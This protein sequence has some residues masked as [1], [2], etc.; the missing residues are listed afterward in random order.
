MNKMKVNEHRFKVIDRITGIVI[1]GFS[2]KGFGFPD[3]ELISV[4]LDE[5]CRVRRV[6]ACNFR[7]QHISTSEVDL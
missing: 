2:A 5:F 3:D 1:G 6:R 7:V 4:M